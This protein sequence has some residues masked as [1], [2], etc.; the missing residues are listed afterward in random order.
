M[1]IAVLDYVKTKTNAPAAAATNAA[2]SLAEAETLVPRSCLPKI[3]PATLRAL[4]QTGNR[5][6][7]VYHLFQSHECGQNVD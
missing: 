7:G 6:A 1:G 5:V 3:Q 2:N 4:W